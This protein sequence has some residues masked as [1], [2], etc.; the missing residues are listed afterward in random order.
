V[1]R[2]VQSEPER[3]GRLVPRVLEELGLDGAAR[4]VRLA[5]RW[6]EAVG[7]EIARHCR[8]TALRGGT[9]EASVDSSARCQELRLRTPEIL[10]ALRRVWGDEAPTHLWLRL[11]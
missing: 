4:I 10:A 3:L 11:G 7:P 8:P 2:R 9:L 5:E 1:R 6:E